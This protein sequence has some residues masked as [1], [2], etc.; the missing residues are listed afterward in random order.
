[1]NDNNTPK[2]A[3]TPRAPRTPQ[4]TPAPA[5][6]Q[7]IAMHPLFAMASNQEPLPMAIDAIDVYRKTSDGR[8]SMI[9]WVP[10]D[11]LADEMALEAQFGP[12]D[13]HL[14][15]RDISRTVILRR[16]N[17]TVGDIEATGVS[18]GAGPAPPVVERRDST[19]ELFG[20]LMRDMQES[21]KETVA[22]VMAFAERGE[23]QTEGVIRAI[24]S[25]FG[26]RA[27]DQQ[28]IIEGLAK[29][30]GGGF[31]P[32]QALELVREGMAMQA[33]A[34]EAAAANEKGVDEIELIKTAAE[35]YT[36]AKRAN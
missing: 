2:R 32:E 17:V 28:A 19:A 3:R 7:A 25:A 6:Q 30:K 20:M 23:K 14:V 27:Q 10:A 16:V 34:A 8:Q 5:A 18:P 31:N 15:G 29:A 12:G 1:M 24:T 11:Q 33:A 13:Y 4:P 9:R 22:L 26:A 21:R 36:A 35:A